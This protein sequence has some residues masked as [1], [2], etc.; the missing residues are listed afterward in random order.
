MDK[1]SAIDWALFVGAGMVLA[2]I[3]SSLVA[4]RFGAPLL[5]VFLVIG[6]L[7]GEDG[8]GGLKFSDY[9]STYLVGSAALSI[10]L[11]DGALR[12]KL[13]LVRRALAPA[14]V[15]ATAGV[16]LT[17]F[18]TGAFVHALVGSGWIESL[19]LGAIVASTDAAAVMF[20]LRTAGL[21]LSPRVGATVEIESGT[22]DPI[23]VFL[24]ILLTRLALAG[25]ATAAA[26][27]VDVVV[28]FAVGAAVGIGGGFLVVRALNR[29]DM[30]PGLH[31]PFVVTSAV[32]IFGLASVWDGSGLL[33]A[34]L[35]G[36]VVGNRPVKAYPAI[37]SFQGAMTWLCQ[38]AMFLMLGLL[39]TPSD[40]LDRGLAAGAVAL[41]LMVVGRPL[42]VWLCLVPFRMPLREIA[43]IGWIGLR[44]AVSIFLAAIPT[45]AGLPG[46][47]DYFNVAFVVV[48]VSLLVQGWT[49]GLAGRW[50]G[51]ATPA[52]S[53]P[54]Q[55]VEIDLPGQTGREL[56]GYPVE[57]ESPLAR[58][59]HL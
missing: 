16:V 44:G 30:P 13:R 4:K 37:E 41:F 6:M 25:D 50:T 53:V 28:D 1:L 49:V 33:A 19:L 46:A 40:F 7:A 38:I 18:L 20:L 29:L 8:P 34:Y 22:N 57:P 51:V 5:L 17:A 48:L 21:T 42:A 35:A 31:P 59:A 43:F 2:G 58:G 36:L 56:V 11:F 15:L 12:T 14:L 54:V 9:E 55:R 39:V 26:V 47:E 10:I 52:T 3:L 27:A 23:A 45:L 24:V 32:A